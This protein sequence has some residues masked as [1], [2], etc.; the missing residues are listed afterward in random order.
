MTQYTPSFDGTQAGH[1]LDRRFRDQEGFVA[2]GFQEVKTGYFRQECRLE[3]P[4]DRDRILG[5]SKTLCSQ[6]NVFI[7]PVLRTSDE[8]VKSNGLGGFSAF[9]DLDGDQVPPAYAALFDIVFSGTPGHS[10]IYLNFD[11]FTYPFTIEQ[12]NWAMAKAFG[13]D[14]K[15]SNDSFLRLPGT[16]NHKNPDYPAPVVVVQEAPVF[17]IDAV[18]HLLDNFAP[19][20]SQVPTHPTAAQV[21]ALEYEEVPELSNY[22]NGRLY[23]ECDSSAKEGRSGQSYSFIM[24]CAEY[25]LSLNQVYTLA[26]AHKPTR[27]KFGTRRGEIERQVILLWTKK[28]AQLQEE[29]KSNQGFLDGMAKW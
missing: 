12:I 29:A 22:L 10:H 21:Q 17:P 1:Y 16:L 23:E 27:A 6:N 4:K 11:E 13:G 20:L 15:W 9:V 19:T 5:L 18:K 28:Q 7:C 14:A 24:A 26:S 25:G 2:L 8:R 3:W